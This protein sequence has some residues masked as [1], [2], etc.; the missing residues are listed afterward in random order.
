MVVG[1]GVANGKATSMFLFGHFANS[2][3]G[4]MTFQPAFE[5]MEMERL[6]KKQYA[7]TMLRSPNDC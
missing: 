4:Y 3:A 6:K 1:F 7:L 5:E 2:P